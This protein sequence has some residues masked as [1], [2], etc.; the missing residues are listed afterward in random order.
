MSQQYVTLAA[1]YDYNGN[2][3]TL[4]ANIGGGTAEFDY[5]TSMAGQFTGFGGGN[6]DFVNTYSYDWQSDMTRIVQ[7]SQTPEGD[8]TANDVAAKTVT[9][10][11]DADQR[12]TSKNF[13]NA[14]GTTDP[15]GL[16]SSTLVAGA[17]YSYDHDSNLTGLTYK[18]GADTLVAGYHYDYNTAGLVTDEYSFADSSAGTPNTSY[19]S[20]SSNWGETAYSYDPDAAVDRQRHAC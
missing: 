16:N 3:T 14:D 13:Y 18:D 9:F 11:Y 1:D 20:G 12:V 10:G 19:V 5:P 4:A 15:T 2:L 6:D 7:T 17:A 8:G